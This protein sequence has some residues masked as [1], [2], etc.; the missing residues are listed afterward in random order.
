MEHKDDAYRDS[1]TGLQGELSRELEDDGR[2][3]SDLPLQLPV[4]QILVLQ[5]GQTNG[6]EHMKEDSERSSLQ[7]ISVNR[8]FH[9]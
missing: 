1:L 8:Y 7:W 3:G 2:V 9:Q 5:D 6:T 4:P